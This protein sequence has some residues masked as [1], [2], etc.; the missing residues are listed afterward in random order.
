MQ[1]KMRIK[2]GRLRVLKIK[3]AG[4]KWKLKKGKIN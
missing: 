1:H 4:R 3:S 2:K